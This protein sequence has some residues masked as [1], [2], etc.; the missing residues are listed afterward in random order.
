[1]ASAACLS[2]TL[3]LIEVIGQLRR[4]HLGVQTVV[5]SDDGFA[6]ASHLEVGRVRQS[7]FR[8]HSEELACGLT[9]V[10]DPR[11]E[12]L[13][14]GGERR[15]GAGA[16][17]SPPSANVWGVPHGR[18]QPFTRRTVRSGRPLVDPRFSRPLVGHGRVPVG[19]I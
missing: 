2:E 13:V 4:R 15:I 8:A 7:F 3:V 9:G 5:E 19:A 6:M 11:P 10:N 18:S 14:F 12:I 17:S 1:V 16:T